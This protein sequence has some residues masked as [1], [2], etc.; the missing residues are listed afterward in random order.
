[1]RK[2]RPR[3]VGSDGGRMAEDA[4]SWGKRMPRKKERCKEAKREGRELSEGRRKIQKIIE[5]TW[6]CREWRKDAGGDPDFFL[7]LTKHYG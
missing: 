4:G 7:R 6:K 3:T 1:M 2:L 5:I